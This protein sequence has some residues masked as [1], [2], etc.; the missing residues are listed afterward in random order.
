MPLHPFFSRSLPLARTHTTHSGFQADSAI[1][2]SILLCP[3]CHKTLLWMFAPREA[4][5]RTTISAQCHHQR[6]MDCVRCWPSRAWNGGNSGSEETVYVPRLIEFS[7]PRFI[8]IFSPFVPFGCRA[9]ARALV[10]LSVCVRV[11]VCECEQR[12]FIFSTI[13]FIFVRAL[14]TSRWQTRF[15]L[16]SNAS[17][18]VRHIL[19][20]ISHRQTRHSTE[21]G[22]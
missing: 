8:S 2:P 6:R 12:T 1:V 3:S 10:E 22:N 9:R 16:V 4:T 15:I 14:C 18:P 19:A 11:R 20:C 5:K 17:A 21:K 7:F 13:A